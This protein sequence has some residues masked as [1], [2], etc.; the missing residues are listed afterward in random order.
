MREEQG[1]KGER[2]AERYLRERGYRVLARNAVATGAI[3]G[4]VISEADLVCEAPDGKTI[5]LVEVKTRSKGDG[6]SAMGNAIAPERQIDRRKVRS[7][8]AMARRLVRANRWHDRTLRID[9]VAVEIVRREG[10]TEE[11][12][13]R[14]HVSAIAI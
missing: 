1:R 10:N 14:H 4:G 6:V 12:T 9:V 5:V 3:R 7:L 2:H 11:T 13:V 8:R